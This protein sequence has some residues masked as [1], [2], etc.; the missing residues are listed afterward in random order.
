MATN[1]GQPDGTKIWGYAMGLSSTARTAI[2]NEANDQT[3]PDLKSLNGEAPWQLDDY[4]GY[5]YTTNLRSV[6]EG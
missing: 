1:Y 6:M 2:Q 3:F 4:N 5:T